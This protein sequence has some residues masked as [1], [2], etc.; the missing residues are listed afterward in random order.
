VF[1]KNFKKINIV[2]NL[3]KETGFP[4][5]YSK[6]IVDDFIDILFSN[7]KTG[8]FNLKNFGSFKIITKNERMGRNPK[9]K[10][11]FKIDSRKT[12]AFKISKKILSKINKIYE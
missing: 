5:N 3:S 4:V 11:E 9:T 12:V 8:N 10:K 7:I 2:N 6:K 1:K